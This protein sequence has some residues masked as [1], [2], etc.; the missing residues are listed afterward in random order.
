MHDLEKIMENVKKWAFNVGKMQK[1]RLGSKGLRVYSKTSMDDLVTEVDE[2]SEKTLLEAIGTAYPEHGYLS[3]ECGGANI[4][5]EY[6]WVIDPL[7][8][9]TNY[10]QGIP[11]F[12]ISL[13][14]QYRGDTVLGVV[15]QPV[16]DEM[17]TAVKGKGAYLN[18][19]EI[20]VSAKTDLAKCVL[21][22]GFPYD[23]AIHKQNNANY[24]SYFVPRVR[25]LRRFGAAAYDLAGVA[26]GRLDGFWE[27]N[28]S[29][30]DVA[31]GILLVE[32]AGGRVELLEKRGISLIAGNDVICNIIRNSIEEVDGVTQDSQS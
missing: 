27:L 2:H 18:G 23:K 22:T 32:E 24:F 5:A 28:L 1:D 21:G 6:V 13:A 26:A 20:S 10:T 7:D 30:W 14:L 4:D 16:L 15:Y 29:L 31:A 19:R 25:G 12:A 9:T 3:E 11:I 8:G 17:F